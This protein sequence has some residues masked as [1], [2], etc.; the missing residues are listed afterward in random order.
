MNSTSSLVL[1]AAGA[2]TFLSALVVVTYQLGFIQMI[3]RLG[4]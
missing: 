1:L 2:V 3:G 4:G